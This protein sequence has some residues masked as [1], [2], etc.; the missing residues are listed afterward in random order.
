MKMNDH[1]SGGATNGLERLL[2]VLGT[3]ETEPVLC[4]EYE[5][6][7]SSFDGNGFAVLA[8]DNFVSN[9]QSTLR[10]EMEA[11]VM[12]E[13]E[14]STLL[15]GPPGALLGPDFESEINEMENELMELSRHSDS[16]A[17]LMHK[18]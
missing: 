4:Q 1:E 3:E 11:I 15:A 8:V 9:I 18:V 6:R 2:A 7:R 14:L 13:A 10:T 12:A 17:S 5:K 16:T